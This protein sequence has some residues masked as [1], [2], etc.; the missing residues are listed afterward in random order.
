MPSS[1][2]D[3][4]RMEIWFQPICGILRSGG[5]QLDAAGQK[6][7]ALVQ[8]VLVALLKKQVEPEADPQ[9][10]F[11]GSDFF[12]DDLDQAALLQVGHGVTESADARQHQRSA[13]RMSS[14]S[15]LTTTSAP[16]FS[17]GFLHAA[18]VA[19]AVIDDG[20]HGIAIQD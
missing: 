18:E 19:H 20:D 12:L 9:E 5:Q 14:G 7:K 11:A 1:R 16:T 17:Q 6:P 15:R 4:L 3:C 2:R 8:A 13:R 10:G